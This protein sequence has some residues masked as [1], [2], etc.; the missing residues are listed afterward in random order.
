MYSN[1][2]HHLYDMFAELLLVYYLRKTLAAIEDM[3]LDHILDY[4]N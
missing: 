2:S 1:Y 3:L 4:L